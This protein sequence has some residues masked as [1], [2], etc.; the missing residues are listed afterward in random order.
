MIIIEKSHWSMTLQHLKF[1]GTSLTVN[2]TKA[3]FPSLSKNPLEY[4]KF[5]NTKKLKIK[6]N[7]SAGLLYV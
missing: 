7:T 3:G 4:I 2:A 5:R 1:I 6:C